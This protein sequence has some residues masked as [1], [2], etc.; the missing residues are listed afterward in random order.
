MSS[1]IAGERPGGF[2]DASS[3]KGQVHSQ[4]DVPR[5]HVSH[6][7][8]VLTS[9]PGDLGGE[10]QRK[11]SDGTRIQPY[12]GLRMRIGFGLHLSMTQ[13]PAVRRKQREPPGCTPLHE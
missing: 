5:Q 4:N 1:F 13:D 7:D 2:E 6:T 10:Q 11:H 3:Q 12:H 8:R 9:L